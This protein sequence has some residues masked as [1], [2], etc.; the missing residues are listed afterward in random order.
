MRKGVCVRQKIKVNLPIN[1]VF[2]PQPVT[3][4][5]LSKSSCNTRKAIE[6]H[7]RN[8]SH[9]FPQ[10]PTRTL[11][12]ASSLWPWEKFLSKEDLL[13][14]I[15]WVGLLTVENSRQGRTTFYNIFNQKRRISISRTR[16]QFSRPR[17]SAPYCWV[18]PEERRQILSCCLPDT[19]S[20]EPIRRPSD[21][22]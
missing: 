12:Q 11:I 9:A 21:K 4:E 19:G 14:A 1:K 6:V 20:R 7:I 13:L 18:G 17:M 3:L 15:E 10:L 22:T 8:I 2:Q 16:R 5:K